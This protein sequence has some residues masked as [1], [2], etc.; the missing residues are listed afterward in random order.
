VLPGRGHVRPLRARG[1]AAPG[2]PLRIPDLLHA[3]S[4]GSVAGHAG[5]HLRV[6]IHDRRADRARRRERFALRR[7]IGGGGSP[8]GGARAHPGRSRVVVAGGLHP[9]SLQVLRTIVGPEN[10]VALPAEGGRADVERTAR[11]L[12]PDTAALVLAYPNFFGIVD[13]ALPELARRA[14]EA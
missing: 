7:R 14:R 5:R 10:V 4:A 8:P 9:N 6:P 3:L 12:G 11:E 2:V 13:D 1:L